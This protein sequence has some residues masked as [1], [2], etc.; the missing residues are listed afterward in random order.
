MTR[1]DAT[2]ESLGIE[3]LDEPCLNPEDATVLEMRYINENMV[4]T[5]QSEV[6]VQSIDAADKNPK[7]ITR[8][9]GSVS[10][11][12]SSRPLPTV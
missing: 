11:L 3:I 1:P 12:H 5:G 10:D 9:I 4:N 2:D 8:W 7:E 6:T